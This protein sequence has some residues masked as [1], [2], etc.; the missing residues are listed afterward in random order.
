MTTTRATWESGRSSDSDSRPSSQVPLPRQP[1]KSGDN[2]G[3]SPSAD[4]CEAGQVE[5]GA[6]ASNGGWC[7]RKLLAFLPALL[8]GWASA[9]TTIFSQD[10]NGTWTT[11]TP[12]TGWRITYEGNPDIA[13]WH[14]EP[15]HGSNPWFRNS[16]RYAAIYYS[17]SQPGIHLDSLISPTIDCAAY[18]N[19]ALRCST[20]FRRTSSSPGLRS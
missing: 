7:A 12:P 10:F 8:L 5:A 2:P 15:D 13:A 19:V 18:Y 17:F 14:D 9:Q 11:A 16:T 1:R 4:P 20:F 6:T 3:F